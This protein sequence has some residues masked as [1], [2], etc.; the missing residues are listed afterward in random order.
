MCQMIFGRRGTK[1][2]MAAMPSGQ[3][4]IVARPL[5]RAIEKPK[6]FRVRVIQTQE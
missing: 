2:A 1:P 3:K 5:L 4:N 6:D